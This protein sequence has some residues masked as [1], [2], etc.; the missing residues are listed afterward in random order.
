MRGGAAHP[1]LGP[2]HL[3]S[4]FLAAPAALRRL[5]FRSLAAGWPMAS[6]PL[7]SSAPPTR[8]LGTC[9][10][11]CTVLEDVQSGWESACIGLQVRNMSTTADA[12]REVCCDDQDCEIWEWGNMRDIADNEGM[13]ICYAGKGV[14]C[15]GERLDNFLVLAGQRISHGSVR[16]T[17]D[18]E[19]GTWCVGPDMRQASNFTN[20]AGALAG[21]QPSAVRACQQAC[22]GD[23]TC[24]L[25]EHS[26]TEGCWVGFAESCSSKDP[27]S[28]TMVAG[29]QVEH[30]CGESGANQKY[31][32][33]DYVMVFG[34]IAAVAFLMTC[35][36]M[37]SLLFCV[38][39]R[40]PLT[41]RSQLRKRQRRKLDISE[42]NEEDGG[43][44]V[45][46]VSPMSY[47]RR[48]GDGRGGYAEVDQ[49]SSSMS[50]RN[51]GEALLRSPEA[52][53]HNQQQRQL[54]STMGSGISATSIPPSVTSLSSYGP[55]VPANGQGYPPRVLNGSEVSVSSTASPEAPWHNQQQRQLMAMSAGVPAGA[56][57]P[58]RAM[59]AYSGAVSAPLS[60]HGFTG[61]EVLA[62]SNSSRYGGY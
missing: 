30:V 8:K 40:E 46:T 10:N 49:V 56:V 28:S 38:S 18:L 3:I 2:C 53:W 32:D 17:V 14:S 20:E 24:G 33:T 59:S 5:G 36:G 41:N 52:P 54:T 62:P 43:S 22:F 35:V 39:L 16:Q 6:A 25:W 50:S 37:V 44:E 45:D 29:Q 9:T 7:R 11:K 21:A 51:G 27:A 61:G 23:A 31:A 48:N 1:L 15:G 47:K 34:I 60:R 12:C 57:A 13:G 42:V 55:C 4:R 58:P 19:P 26:Y